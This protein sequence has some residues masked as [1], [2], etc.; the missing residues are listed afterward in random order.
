[1]ENKLKQLF[2]LFFIFLITVGCHKEKTE[3]TGIAFDPE[4]KP[5]MH[6]TNVSTLISDSGITR[7]RIKAPVWNVYSKAKEPYSYFPEGI[8]VERFDSLLNVE[9][10]IKADTAYHYERKNLWRL[11]NNVKVENLE[12]SK[13][14][15]SE[16]FWDEKKA[17]IYSDKFIRIEENG[18]ITTGI[19]FESDQEMT[20]YDIYRSA[21]SYSF[22]EEPA[23]TMD[24]V[25]AV[26][27]SQEVLKTHR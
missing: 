16:L 3:I 7:Y 14:E 11:I 8:Y 21:G 9:G 26:K 23:N 1:M 25:S 6:S 2:T 10:Y 17:K 4:K 18:N 5:M 13:F 22:E 12:G 19:G 24:S 27:P 20:N 15:T